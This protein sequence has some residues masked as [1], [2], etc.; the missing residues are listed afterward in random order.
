MKLRPQPVFCHIPGRLFKL[1]QSL[2][3][4]GRVEPES[5]GLGVGNTTALLL[6]MQIVRIR[7]AKVVATC[8]PSRDW[9]V[10]AVARGTFLTHASSVSLI[11][12]CSVA[13]PWS[14]VRRTDRTG[15]GQGSG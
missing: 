5:R 7:I 15:A 14:D 13:P 9:G 11:T 8:S 4:R 3:Y 6:S 10:A 12:C 1:H 2:G